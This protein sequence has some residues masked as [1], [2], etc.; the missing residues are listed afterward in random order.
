VP[1]EDPKA[2]LLEAAA[3]VLIRD[4]RCGLTT[5]RLAR[6]AGVN[7]GLVHYHYGSLDSVLAEL[8]E[9]AGR[10]WLGSLAAAVGGQGVFLDRWRAVRAGLARDVAGG[11]SKLRA[12][13]ALAAANDPGLDQRWL[14]FLESRFELLSVLVAGMLQE[15]RLSISLGP[16]ATALISAVLHGLERDGLDGLDAGHPDLDAWIEGWLLA[17]SAGADP[18]VR[19]G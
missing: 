6:E 18:G 16:P 5:R 14:T 11:E 2:R 9:A 13:L 8:M 15:Y 1:G 7:H 4:G 3:R 17:L 12:E 19:P 10:R